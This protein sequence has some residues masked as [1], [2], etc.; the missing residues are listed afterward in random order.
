MSTLVLFF[1]LMQSPTPNAPTNVIESTRS[2]RDWKPAADPDSPA[3]AGQ[4]S[5]LATRDFFGQPVPLSPT[6]I[7][8]RWT[9]DYLYLFY[10]CPY[11]NLNLKPNPVTTAET[12]KLWDWDVAEAFLGSDFSHIGLYKE[13]QVSPRGEYVDLDINREDPKAALG[14][15]WQSGFLVAARIDEQAHLW[16]GEMRIP[17][18]SLGLPAPK[19][20][21]QLRAGLYRIEGAEPNRIYVTWQPTGK[22]SFHEPA[23]FGL[24]VLR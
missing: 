15:G 11:K 5:V 24:L 19:P 16:Y 7:R 12:D 14:V 8:S 18:A 10:V 9:N 4:K 22:K 21:D 2:E 3:W 20:G 23:A 1:A 17:F 6:E 13:F